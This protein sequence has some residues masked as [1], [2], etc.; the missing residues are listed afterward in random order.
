MVILKVNF[1]NDKFSLFK[2]NYYT[3]TY[4]HNFFFLFLQSLYCK[5][6]NLRYSFL[7]SRFWK[8][9]MTLKAWF[10]NIFSQKALS[11]NGAG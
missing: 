5:V 9:L 1:S 3:N 7:K 4:S 6:S 10:H 2:F 11:N 8:F